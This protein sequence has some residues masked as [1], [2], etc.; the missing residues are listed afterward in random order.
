MSAS[1]TRSVGIG[2]DSDEEEFKKTA[3]AEASG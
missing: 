3:L 1:N 2:G